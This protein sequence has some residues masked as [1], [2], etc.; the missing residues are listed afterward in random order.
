MKKQAKKFI[1]TSIAM[2]VFIFVGCLASAISENGK[3]NLSK[4]STKVYDEVTNDNLEYGRKAKVNLSI[5]A[6][7]YTETASTTGK[8]DIVLVL[9]GSN[10][11]SYGPYG[12]NDNS[13]SRLSSAKDTT[14]S[15]IESIMTDNDDINLGL[16]EYGTNVKAS[17]GMTTNKVVAKTYTNN[18][19]AKGGTNLQAGIK[20]ANDLLDKDGRKDA[21]KVVII[22][23]DGIPT[24]FNYTDKHGN[25]S[26]KGTGNTN[27]AV[28]VSGFGYNCVRKS[29]SEAAKEV[30]DNLK[31]DYKDAD[32]YTITFGNES[33]AASILKDINP[34]NKNPIYENLT[35]ID[36]KQLK[37]K[38]DKII[39][40]T[41]N[42]I[43]K[44]SVVTDT[45]PNTFTLTTES[46]TDLTNKGVIITNNGDGSTTLT[47]NV[48]NIEANKEKS[49][50][51][52]V[53][54][55]DNYHGSMFTN[56]KATLS[57]TVDESNPYYDKT[58]L[59]LDFDKPTVEIPAITK[60]DHYS[61]NPSYI[62]YG[63]EI[64]NGSS[65]LNNDLNKNILTDKKSNSMTVNDEIVVDENENTVKNLDGTYNIYKDGVLQGKLKMNEDGT[66]IFT[67][68]VTGEVTFTYHIKTTINEFLETENVYSNSSLVTLKINERKTLNISGS[69]I[70]N[71]NNNQDGLRPDKIKVGLYQNGNL[72][73]EITVEDDWSY[74]FNNLY[75]YELGHENDAD[76]EFNYTVKELSKV[77]NYTTSYDGYD[78]INT[79]EVIKININGSKTWVDNDNQDGLRPDEININLI[80]KV[81]NETV[82]NKSLSITASDNWSYS[83]SNLDKYYNGKEISYSVVE[84]E[85]DN[86]STSYDGYNITN[87]H[88][89]IKIKINGEKKWVDSNNFD[90]L[91]PDEININLIGKVGNETVVNK[92]LSVTASDNWSYS[93]SNLDKYYN[94]KEISYSVV[95]DEVPYYETSYDDENPFIII[96]TH[97]PKNITVSGSKTW[98][99]NDNLYGHPDNIT[100][101][102]TGMVDDEV[103]ISKEQAIGSSDNWEYS[104]DN[105]PEYSN[106]KLIN[107]TINE[108]AVKDYDTTIDGYDI[109]NTYNPE[110]ID[111]N[112]VKVWNDND[113]QDGIRPNEITVELLANGQKV[114][115]TTASAENNWT[116]SF[117]NQVKYANGEEIN[118][119]INEVDVNGYTS[120]IKDFT[121]TNTHTPETISFKVIKE[122]DDYNNQDGIR[123]DEIN[124][125]LIGTVN[126]EVIVSKETVVSVNDNWTYTFDNLDKYYHGIEIK[127]SII[128]S[129]VDGYVPTITD[130]I[131]VD[132]TTTSTIKN[133][134]VPE[135]VNITINKKWDDYDNKY[136]S[137]PDSI[138]V[139][140]LANGNV[141]EVIT[142]SKDNNWTYTISLDKYSNGEEIIYTVLEEEVDNYYASYDGFDITNHYKSHGKTEGKTEV[143]SEIMP[144]HTGVDNNSNG[145]YLIILSFI[146][147]AI[148]KMF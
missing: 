129:S 100:V 19:S 3:I 27:D 23:T 99:D 42:I 141:I 127:Y 95:E 36:G 112:G 113:N 131:S 2:I 34:E 120:E 31:S 54:A 21:K 1:F 111:L 45:I 65:I 88:D 117:E 94:G 82:V 104:F 63:E 64:I 26:L 51:Y 102:L 130:P 61:N 81:G 134:H 20:A 9:D 114:A 22:L 93:F 62:G 68:F 53:V 74:S 12:K 108:K 110:T 11:M 13:T 89:P 37:E 7:P 57:T 90:G 28:C 73:K 85:V 126:G 47:W 109:I 84:D 146:L 125:K 50:T 32:V 103:I 33:E 137:R 18:L 69:K 72:I 79:H 58:N 14:N 55:N 80:G 6:N 43:G 15:F 128:E 4:T 24:Y 123:P 17:L 30:L 49:L 132:K 46:I 135:K 71:D 52:E 105:L 48:G 25:T 44:N 124:I 133:T 106:G 142:L 8:L 76:Y 148:R 92:S 107:Y 147:V 116:F 145:L 118:Y 138:I 136:N 96:N 35:A 139:K 78:I 140:I 10:S 121:I 77:D 66:F 91:R 16:V 40:Q 70:W 101:I 38:F 97:N 67:P 5:D 87:T 59:K 83:F 144:P 29:P 98:V 75:R 119:T 143:K 39:T 122:W 41:K 56:T 86:Y 115:Q 60:D